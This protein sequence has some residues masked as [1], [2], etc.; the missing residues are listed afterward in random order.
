MHRMN[1][2]V[3]EQMFSTETNKA[4]GISAVKALAI[5]SQEGQKIWTI[6]QNNVDLALNSINLGADTETAIR[7]SVAAGKVVTTHQN[8]INFNGWVGEGFITIDPTTG[9]GAYQIA[10]GAN[11]GKLFGRA[12]Q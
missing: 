8:K 12:L 4:Q 3:P 6:T 7:N 5:A 11:G 2:L 10:G 1:H 9:A